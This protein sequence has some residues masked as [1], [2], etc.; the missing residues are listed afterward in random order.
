MSFE[1]CRKSTGT[2]TRENWRVTVTTKGKN[3][4]FLGLR[5][6]MGT[7]CQDESKFLI[8]GTKI[9]F[10]KAVLKSSGSEKEIGWGMCVGIPVRSFLK[11]KFSR[12][13]SMVQNY[14]KYFSK[15]PQFR[16]NLLET[17]LNKNLTADRKIIVK[18]QKNRKFWLRLFFI[19]QMN[20]WTQCCTSN[21]PK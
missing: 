19:L 12:G 9:P 5:N 16:S 2:A 13:Q 17:I 11:V 20:L 10:L 1:V 8:I 7:V 3:P 14:H 15:Y 6:G 21:F 18:F 4:E